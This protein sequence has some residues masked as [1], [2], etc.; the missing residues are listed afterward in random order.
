MQPA[1]YGLALLSFSFASRRAIDS[2]IGGSSERTPPPRG[3]G[4]Y[5]RRSVHAFDS[6]GVSVRRLGLSNEHELLTVPTRT[7]PS[8]RITVEEHRVTECDDV[9]LELGKA[10]MATNRAG[11]DEWRKEWR[12]EKSWEIQS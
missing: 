11:D 7:V 6:K 3:D 4:I 10:S 12:G 9:D 8:V 2:R 5:V 1:L